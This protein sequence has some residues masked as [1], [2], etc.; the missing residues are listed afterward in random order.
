MVR[1]FAWDQLRQLDQERLVSTFPILI[2][3]ILTHE[4]PWVRKAALYPIRTY[5]ENNKASPEIEAALAKVMEFDT[6]GTVVQRAYGAMKAIER[7]NS[8]P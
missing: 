3:E 2:D 6:N 1:Q 7:F 5:V 8:T 4:D